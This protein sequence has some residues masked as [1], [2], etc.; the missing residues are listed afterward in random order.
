MRKKRRCN[1][2]NLG[3]SLWDKYFDCWNDPQ[4][5]P[6]YQ[7]IPAFLAVKLINPMGENPH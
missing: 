5:N 2:S 3:V 7:K 1:R 6:K 4:M